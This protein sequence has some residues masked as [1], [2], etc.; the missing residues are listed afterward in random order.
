MGDE[1]VIETRDSDWEKN[2]ERESK[3]VVVFFHSPTCS[4]CRV[5]EPYFEEYAKEFGDTAVFFK[6]NVSDN[7]H[8]AQRYGIMSTPTFKFFCEGRPVQE[9]VGAAYPPLLKRTV[10]EV[11]QHGGECVR[12]STKIDYEMTGYA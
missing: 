6:L 8:T 10:E 4:N 7:P 12:K 1:G 9:L 5:M 2:V 11:L 3:P